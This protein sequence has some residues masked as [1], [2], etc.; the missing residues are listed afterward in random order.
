MLDLSSTRITPGMEF[1]AFCINMN[2][3]QRLLELQASYSE[4][5]YQGVEQALSSCENYATQSSD[6]ASDARTSK[7]AAESAALRAESAATATEG[8]A[9]TAAEVSEWRTEVA[10]KKVLVDQA[11]IRINAARDASTDSAEKAIL[12]SNSLAQGV[13][14]AEAAAA[15]LNNVVV[16]A[17]VSESHTVL[18]DGNGSYVLLGNTPLL[19]MIVTASVVGTLASGAEISIPVSAR[20]DDF[21]GLRFSVP[22][23][24]TQAQPLAGSDPIEV[25]PTG[26]LPA[27]DGDWTV[28][29]DY[30]MRAVT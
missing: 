15:K 1:P 3:M 11:E 4:H 29:I 8:V 5:K 26:E 25:E 12:A 18:S 28:K 9:A 24:T 20:S 19:N 21:S 30:W 27:I 13:A 6:S 16:F 23:A 14:A 22:P 10:N 7:S 17:P 2:E